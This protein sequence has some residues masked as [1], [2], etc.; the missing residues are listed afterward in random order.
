MPIPAM[1]I[2]FALAA[3]TIATPLRGSSRH[4]GW[5]AFTA[6]AVAGFL[7]GIST[8]SF[9][10]VLLWPFALAAILGA[11]RL[12]VW[13]PALGFLC[14]TGLVGVLVFAL[15]VGEGSSSR[16]YY[17]WLLGG[18][19]IAAAAVVTFAAVRTKRPPMPPRRARSLA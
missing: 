12:S 15:N 6:W 9:I 16:S 5:W 7:S 3:V 11:A 19:S 18:C 13:P 14:G 17:S 2:L 1:I 10:G 4:V 8:I